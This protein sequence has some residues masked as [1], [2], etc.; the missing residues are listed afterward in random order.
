MPNIDY[1]K[2]SGSS[3][4]A[5]KNKLSKLGESTTSIHNLGKVKHANIQKS[6]QSIKK[7]DSCVSPYNKNNQ[8]SQING[9]NK[10]AKTENRFLAKI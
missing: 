2:M 7:K 3:S 6:M 4:L 10:L 5:L 1:V 9:G 8:L